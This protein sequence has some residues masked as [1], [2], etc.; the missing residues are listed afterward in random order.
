MATDR[1]ATDRKGEPAPSPGSA[2]EAMAALEAMTIESSAQA[3]QL[4]EQLA[5]AVFPADQRD[6]EHLTWAET[7]EDAVG[8]AEEASA[9]ARLAAAEKRF[10][11]LVEQIPAV[12]FMAVLGEG[13]NEVYVS[14]HVEQMLGYS[15]KE[16]LENPFLWYWRLHPEDRKLWNDEFT[17]GCATGGPFQAECRF[18]ARDGSTVWVHGEA[19]IVKD[20]LGRPLFLQGVAFDITESKRA[21]EV[22][23]REAVD[24]ARFE[25]ELELARELQTSILPRNFAVAGLEIAG[26]METASEVG[27]DYY[28]VLP[29][30]EGCWFAIGD[31]TGHGMNAGLIMLMVQSAT[32]ALTRAQ[33]SAMPSQLVCLVNEVVYDNVTRR[34]TRDDHVTYTLLRYHADGRMA[35]AGAHED[36]LVWRH[37]RG[38]VEQIPTPGIW[39]GRR[40]NISAF[41]GDVHLELDAGDILL[42][43]TDGI[44]EARNV[45]SEQFDLPRLSAALKELHDR[46][47]EE[48]RDGVLARA[49]AWMAG[50]VQQDD[51]TLLV[52]RRRS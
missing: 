24:R 33:P 50:A 5:A 9:E 31:V 10:R 28:D 38:T 14:P 16:W 23:M 42:L 39:I 18:V 21:Q 48:I 11:T 2:E 8:L 41:I 36:V 13:K 47:V 30:P 43:Y 26:G 46:P 44:T 32:S 3:S 45:R 52:V 17:R 6:L 51:M 49:R 12:T 20:E 29:A 40:R 34:L 4:L 19:R 15:Q 22:V 27:G 1:P 37:A 25:E 35:F 7:G